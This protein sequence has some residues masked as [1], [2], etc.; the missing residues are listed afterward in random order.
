MRMSPCHRRR[1]VLS[2][3]LQHHGAA[4]AIKL[5]DQ[6]FMLVEK[7][8]ARHFV[9]HE[10]S[11]GRSVQVGALLELSQLSDDLR[12][13]NDPSQAKPWSQRLREG[14]QINDVANRVAT[15]AAQVFTVENDQ[16]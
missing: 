7:S 16:R 10:L 9:G 8:I 14:A 2:Q 12:R 13:S 4:F 15:V 3:S 1:E 5:T 6:L 11:K